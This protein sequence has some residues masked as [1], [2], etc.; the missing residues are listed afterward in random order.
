MGRK[1]QAAI[2]QLATIDPESV[3]RA[4]MF[5]AF[6]ALAGAAP[7]NRIADATAG[8]AAETSQAA[9][10]SPPA[11][12]N[13][14]DAQQNAAAV[15]TEPN[16]QPG[17][18]RAAATSDPTDPLDRTNPSDPSD[19]TDAG[20]P[21][22]TPSKVLPVE[23][24]QPAPPE[25]R[26]AAPIA[27]QHRGPDGEPLSGPLA[28]GPGPVAAAPRRPLLVAAPLVCGLG[29]VL[30]LWLILRRTGGQTVS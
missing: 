6:G 19:R 11:P 15:A 28:G 12:V 30:L 9:T 29:I 18:P 7:A 13:P 24:A 27:S 8:T 26:G 17:D 14:P 25:T 1:A 10:A 4:D 22:S 21:P 16:P 2:D 20:I 23:P 3:R 5:S